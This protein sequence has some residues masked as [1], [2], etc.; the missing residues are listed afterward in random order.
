M[1]RHR[2]GISGTVNDPVRR[3]LKARGVSAEMVEG[4]LEAA[5]D[6]WDSISRTAKNYDFTLDDWLNDMDLRDIIAGAMGAAEPAER[7]A[8]SERLKKADDRLKKATVKTVSIWGDGMAG[9]MAPDPAKAWWYFRRPS[10]PGEMMRED[11]EIAG[12]E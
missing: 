12:L 10:D 7:E 1:T 8:V 5:V 11:L 4:G 3:Y 6:R 9:D 2:T